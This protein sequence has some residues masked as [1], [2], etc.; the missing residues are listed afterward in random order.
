MMAKEKMDRAGRMP[1]IDMR[2]HRELDKNYILLGRR[3]MTGALLGTLSWTG[4]LSIATGA[5]TVAVPSNRISATN[6]PGVE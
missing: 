2:R 6:A 1:F 4:L 5:V 3:E